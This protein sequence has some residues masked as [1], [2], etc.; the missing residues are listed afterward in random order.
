MLHVLAEEVAPTRN[1][2]SVRLK[3]GNLLA[4]SKVM[5][6]LIFDKISMFKPSNTRIYPWLQ[7]AVESLFRKD[8][9]VAL[10][11]L[12][13][14]LLKLGFNPWSDKNHLW[15]SLA[16]IVPDLTHVWYVN[17]VVCLAY[18]H[19]NQRVILWC[20]LSSEVVYMYNHLRRGSFL[21]CGWLLPAVGI[22][23]LVLFPFSRR[24]KGWQVRVW[25]ISL[26]D[27]TQELNGVSIGVLRLC[28]WLPHHIDLLVFVIKKINIHQSLLV[29]SD[30]TWTSI[31]VSNYSRQSR[32]F[33]RSLD[34]FYKKLVD[35]IS[36]SLVFFRIDLLVH[37]LEHNLI[38]VAFF[39]FQIIKHF[40]SSLSRGFD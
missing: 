31:A 26:L 39:A 16:Q 20:S 32:F 38:L 25:T 7:I 15:L 40:S 4:L 9:A 33:L 3:V 6:I 11:G 28:H 13:E 34:I 2:C 29:V 23:C 12:H 1:T 37:N 22:L 35:G 30:L 5:D 36:I 8:L 10:L 21:N 18:A 24:T 17:L 19:L 14:S 27:I